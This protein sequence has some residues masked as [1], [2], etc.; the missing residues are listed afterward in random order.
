MKA[1]EPY[2]PP[3][4]VKVR[5]SREELAV[6]ACKSPSSSGAAASRTRGTGPGG[7]CQ[8]RGS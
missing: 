2:E 3:E 1:Q 4:I 6:G 8:T 7:L 5:L